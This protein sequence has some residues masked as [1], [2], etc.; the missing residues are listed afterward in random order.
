M[1]L[2]NNRSHSQENIVKAFRVIHRYWQ[3]VKCSSGPIDMYLNRNKVL[4]YPLEL[5]IKKDYLEILE[6]MLNQEEEQDQ[7]N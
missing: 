7:P 5:A 6:L 2:M 4:E 1:L 3:L